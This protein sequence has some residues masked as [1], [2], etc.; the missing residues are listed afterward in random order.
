MLEVESFRKC[1]PLGL[2]TFGSPASTSARLFDVLQLSPHVCVQTLHSVASWYLDQLGLW[3]EANGFL[4]LIKVSHE[5]L[6]E[7]HVFICSRVSAKA[8]LHDECMKRLIKFLTT[9]VVLLIRN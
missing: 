6:N 5:Y 9:S 1:Q 7:P 4:P 3:A 2:W 8:G